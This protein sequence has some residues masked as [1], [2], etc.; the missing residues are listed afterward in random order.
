MPLPDLI[1]LEAVLKRFRVLRDLTQREVEE[2]TG[3]PCSQLS[4]YENG[5]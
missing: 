2:R 1:H 4:G 3:I 5:R